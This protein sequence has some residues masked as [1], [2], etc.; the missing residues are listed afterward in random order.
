VNRT[1]LAEVADYVAIR[2]LQAAYADI[3]SRRA[4][5]ELEPLFTADCDIVVDRRSLDPLVLQ[6][7]TALGRFIADAIARFE[8]FEFTVLNAVVDIDDAA[9]VTGTARGRLWMC[10][11]RQ[12][13]TGDDAAEWSMAYGVYH[14]EY[15]KSDDGRW[16]FARRRYHSLARRLGLDPA[17]EVFPFPVLTP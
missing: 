4:W 17:R 6:G 15:E 5:T 1:D 7:A 14:D 16:R 11:L 12:E 10:E 2:R 13:R 3:V 8:F 9:D